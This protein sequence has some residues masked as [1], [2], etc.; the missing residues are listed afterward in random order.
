MLS[1]G[2]NLFH[3]NNATKNAIKIIT[4]SHNFPLK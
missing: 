1:I 3:S 2:L 4:I